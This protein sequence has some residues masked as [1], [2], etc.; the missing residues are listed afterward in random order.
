VTLQD[1]VVLLGLRID[2]PPVKGT[3]ERDWIKECDRLLGVMPPLTA[4]HGG[5]MKLT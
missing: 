4:I 1:V 2:G 3:N 5:Q